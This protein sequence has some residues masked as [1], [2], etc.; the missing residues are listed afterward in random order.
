MASSKYVWVAES[1]TTQVIYLQ[2]TSL[3]AGLRLLAVGRM[4]LKLAGAVKGQVCLDAAE[5]TVSHLV[6]AVSKL[7]TAPPESQIACFVVRGRRIDVRIT[8]WMKLVKSLNC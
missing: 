1:P 3:N 7:S 2:P 8:P 5:T 6:L 4:Q